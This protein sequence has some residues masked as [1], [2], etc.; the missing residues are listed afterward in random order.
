MGL[1]FRRLGEQSPSDGALEGDEIFVRSSGAEIP[2]KRMIRPVPAA[3]RS[4]PESWRP[5]AA[6]AAAEI[7]LF[8][9]NR[10]VSFSPN[11]VHGKIEN[12]AKVAAILKKESG[13]SG[14]E[15]FYLCAWG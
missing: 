10:I 12:F 1:R 7:P 6:S 14:A 15:V 3:G 9:G 8:R 11:D 2:M 4:W 5:E 13:Q